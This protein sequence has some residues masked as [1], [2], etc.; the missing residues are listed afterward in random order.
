V[1]RKQLRVGS[2]GQLDTGADRRPLE[3]RQVPPAQLD[4]PLPVLERRGEAQLYSPPVEPARERR[5]RGLGVVDDEQVA[6]LDELGQIT[7]PRVHDLAGAAVG[8]HHPDLVAGDAPALGGLSALDRPGRDERR[9]AHQALGAGT[10]SAA[11]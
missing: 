8:D 9:R 11:R 10:R 2:R 5:G 7:E 3:R 6:G 1:A 4:N